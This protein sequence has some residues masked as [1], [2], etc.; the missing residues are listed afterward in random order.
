[1][2]APAQWSNRWV[3]EQSEVLQ[4]QGLQVVNIQQK[5]AEEIT[6]TNRARKLGDL[7]LLQ[8]GELFA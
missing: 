4:K 8:Y 7:W 2:N 3:T 1:M 6:V 5:S